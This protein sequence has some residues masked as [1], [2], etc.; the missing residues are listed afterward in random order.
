MRRVAVFRGSRS[1]GVS[2][3]F[4]IWA[5]VIGVA[6]MCIEPGLGLIVLVLGLTWLTWGCNAGYW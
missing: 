4:G 1:L 6:L 5:V 3:W 2:L